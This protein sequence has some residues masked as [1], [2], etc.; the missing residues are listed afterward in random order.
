MSA[1]KSICGKFVETF[2]RHATLNPEAPEHR[3]LFISALV[4]NLPSDIEK[5]IQSTVVG[6]GQSLNVLIEA[7]TQFFANSLQECR[8]TKQ[9]KASI[10]AL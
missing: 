7:A 5:Q 2:Q 9:L 10:L 6:T 1:S 4:G 3:N 8:R